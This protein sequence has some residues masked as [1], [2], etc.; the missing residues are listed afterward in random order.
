MVEWK[1]SKFPKLD[2]PDQ[3]GR[4]R[5]LDE[6]KNQNYVVVY[7]YPMDNTPGCTIEARGFTQHL[8]DFH[9]LGVEIIGVSTQSPKSHINFCDRHDLKLILLSDEEKR[10]TKQ[11][12]ILNHLTRTAKRTTYLIQPDGKI[13]KEWQSVKPAIHVQEV[14]DYVKSLRPPTAAS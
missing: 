1:R 11:L 2:L 6:F 12:G 14:L 8:D 10:L 4:I 9:N 3:Y 13:V 7:F 5:T